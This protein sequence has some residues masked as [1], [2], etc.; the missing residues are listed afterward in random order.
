[1]CIRSW[2]IC[3]IIASEMLEGFVGCRVARSAGVVAA[4]RDVQAAWLRG[5]CRDAV[6]LRALERSPASG[7]FGFLVLGGR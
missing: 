1:M 4:R 7:P 2:T 6:G 3:V 5:G